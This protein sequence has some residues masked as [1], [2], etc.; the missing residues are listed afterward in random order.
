MRH[1]NR[2]L[3]DVL[4][5]LLIMI[6][7]FVG[8]LPG[9]GGIYV[10]GA[11]LWLLARDHGWAHNLLELL[12]E[13]GLKFIAAVFVDNPLLQVI[14][15][16]VAILLVIG[17][18]YVLDTFSGDIPLTIGTFLNLLGL[19]TALIN[20]RRVQRLAVKLKR[21]CAKKPDKTH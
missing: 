9:P 10:F 11:G 2:L 19:T 20:R 8:I 13:K 3:I 21:L 16:I 17:G 18:I 14:Y 4:G 15:D 7:P 6:S 5:V 1:V 12:K